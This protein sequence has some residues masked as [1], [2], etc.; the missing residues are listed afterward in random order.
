MAGPGLQ[1]QQQE[2]GGEEVKWAEPRD[3]QE[4]RNGFQTIELGDA[5][6]KPD[7][8]AAAAAPMVRR[9]WSRK[10]SRLEWNVQDYTVRL[11]RQHT[12]TILQDIGQH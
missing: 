5:R 4:P 11:R 2:Q 1:P 10:A 9:L 7:G 3:E 6:A 12:L 8:A